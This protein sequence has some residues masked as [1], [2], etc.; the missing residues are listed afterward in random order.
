[1]S[2]NQPTSTVTFPVGA[3]FATDDLRDVPG[4]TRIGISDAPAS[5]KQKLQALIEIGLWVFG[6]VASSTLAY[7]SFRPVFAE[8]LNQMIRH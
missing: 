6:F 2:K 3:Q 5:R 1:M 8:A 4:T 7:L